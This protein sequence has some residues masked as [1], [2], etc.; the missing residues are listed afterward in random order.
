MSHDNG[1]DR[2]RRRRWR[3]GWDDWRFFG[4]S[5]PYP[6][7][8]QYSIAVPPQVVYPSPPVYA[9]PVYQAPVY[10]APVYTPPRALPGQ[11]PGT[12]LGYAGPGLYRVTAPM[13][14]NLRSSPNQNTPPVRTLPTGSVLRVLSFAPAPATFGWVQVLTT[15]GGGDGGYVCLSCPEGGPGGPWLEKQVS[16]MTGQEA[17]STL[18]AGVPGIITSLGFKQRKIRGHKTRTVLAR[19]AVPFQARSLFISRDV[20]K[21]FD[22]K[23]MRVGNL[24][25]LASKDPIPAEM[26]VSHGC[27]GGGALIQFPPVI[28]GQHIFLTVKN[29][30]SHSHHFR[31]GLNGVAIF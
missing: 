22:I 10:Q 24:E 25:L 4:I 31:A 30:S 18:L 23:A 17:S 1:R 6:V 2:D 26:Y 28:P 8:A 16:A 9:A 7:A 29:R 14:L 3:R 12:P 20:A 19:P 21:H 27:N 11:I 15:D 5:Y 13:G